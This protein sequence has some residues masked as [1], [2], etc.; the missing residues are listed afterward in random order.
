MRVPSTTAPAS[1]ASP[2]FDGDG[3]PDLA[4]GDGGR[5]GQVRVRYGTGSEL[6]FGS[7]A[8]TGEDYTAFGDTLLARDL[9]GDG[10]TDLIVGAATPDRS[11]FEIFGGTAGLDPNEAVELDAP[12]GLL[13]FGSAVALVESPVPILVVGAPGTT[14]EPHSGGSIALYRL[15]TDGRPAGVPEVVGEGTPGVAGDP[16]AGDAFGSV[17]A[18]TGSWLFIG[19]PREDVGAVRDA[20]AVVAVHFTGGGFSST[21]LTQDSPRVPGDVEAEDRFGQS[22]AAG[23]G[24]L[25]VGVPLEDR[26]KR[27]VGA[28]QPFEI[29]GERLRAL[30]LLELG[31]LPGDPEAGDAFGT[32]LAIASPCP[33]VPG[34]VV[35]AGAKAID[36]QPLAGAVWL[37]PFQV[38][39]S[40]TAIQLDEGTPGAKEN[41]LFGSAVSTLRTGLGQAD[42]LVI[43]SLGVEEEGVPGRV[44]TLAPPYDHDGVVVIAELVVRE[45]GTVTL[46]PPAG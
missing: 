37:V 43:A 25:V 12:E 35:G 20:G 16:E 14:V 7:R 29:A 21:E 34:V 5:L 8:V 44:L 39:Q 27:D 33:G 23:D 31:A 4:V 28:V 17:L 45:E 22:L 38:S 3:S 32:A 19:V 1:A 41:S 40:C 9:N 2:D 11:L 24:H 26:G 36:G 15:G 30:P 46:S 42:T 18:A 13:G 6:T 10:F